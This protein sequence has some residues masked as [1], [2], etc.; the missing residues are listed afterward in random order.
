VLQSEARWLGKAIET[1]PEE[2]F[3][4]LNLGSSTKEFRSISHPWVAREIFDPMASVG[5]AVIH[6]DIKDGEGVDLVADFTDASDRLTIKK[7]NLRSILCSNMLEHL[8]MPPKQA[9]AFIAQ[10]CP[11]GG[12][13]IVTAPRK[14]G[15]HA[16][17]IDNGFRPTPEE[18]ADLFPDFDVVAAQEVRCRRGAFYFSDMGTRRM[19]FAARMCAP[20][21]RPANWW[22]LLRESPRRTSAACVVLRQREGV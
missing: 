19:R 9:A 13:L 16:D 3:P 22:T 8:P 21:I 1:L 11:P 2:A 12:W 4:L 15:Y 14:Y 20:F 17:P 10:L 18:L 6:T 5:H 7:T